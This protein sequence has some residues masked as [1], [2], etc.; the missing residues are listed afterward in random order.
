[1]I[2]LVNKAR[3]TLFD[4][5]LQLISIL[6]LFTL[7][8]ILL[9]SQCMRSVTLP[10]TAT[11]WSHPAKSGTMSGAYDESAMQEETTDSF[12]EVRQQGTVF[13]RL[14]L[15][16][17]WRC[18]VMNSQ[19]TCFL[20]EVRRTIGGPRLSSVCGQRLARKR[21]SSGFIEVWSIIDLRAW[22]DLPMALTTASVPICNW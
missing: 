8:C 2:I 15:T 20:W 19:W 11:A 16:R 4:S 5:A 13:D 17:S 1:M 21:M 7:I 12:W 9:L 18:R 14:N 22:A 10:Q 6:S 3:V